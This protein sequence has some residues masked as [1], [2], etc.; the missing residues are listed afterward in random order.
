MAAESCPLQKNVLISGPP[1]VGKTTAIRKVVEALGDDA[2]GFF[3]EEIREGGVR[4]GFRL[5]T[6]SGERRILAHVGMQS[7]NRVGKYGVDIQAVELAVDA[8]Q[9]AIRSGKIVIIDEIGEMELLSVSFREAVLAAILNPQPAVATIR[10]AA[11]PYCDFLKSRADVSVISMD[12]SNREEVPGM[13]MRVLTVYT[14]PNA[15]C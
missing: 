15:S 12:E 5:T 8:I 13:V 10:E 4:K 6:L 14:S 1:G 3:T 9:H 7:K 11:N 2:G